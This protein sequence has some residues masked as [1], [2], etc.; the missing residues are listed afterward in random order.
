MRLHGTLYEITDI[1]SFVR[2][3]VTNRSQPSAD[4]M[5][6]VSNARVNLNLPLNRS[7][8]AGRFPPSVAESITDGSGR[9]ELD[10]S[11]SSGASIFLSASVQAEDSERTG[12]E[13]H[14]GCWYRSSPFALGSID[15]IQQDI[16]IARIAVPREAG[17]SQAQLATALAETQ[18]EVADLEWI[19]GRIR[20]DGITLSCGGKGAKASGRLML[21]PHR[22]DDLSK[23]LDHSVEDF[24]L[25]LPGPAWLVGLVISKDAVEA[26]LRTGLA[27]LAGEISRQLKLSA[28]NLFSARLQPSDPAALDRVVS[29]A[30]LSF[31]RLHYEAIPVAGPSKAS[32]TI[33]GEA[34]FGFPGSIG[35]E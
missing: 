27:D 13:Q 2:Q 23:S 11:M 10:V 32:R 24:H 35:T 26:S 20:S 16:Y 33:V 31:S 25:E 14:P 22:S 9:F 4:S 34:C 29:E 5:S 6:A 30:T 28:I 7:N 21:N 17:F 18:K 1:T 12:H 19:K 8:Q 3:Y 15:R